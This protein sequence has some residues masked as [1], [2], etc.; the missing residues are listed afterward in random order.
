MTVA[1]ALPS[2][3]EPEKHQKLLDEVQR[4]QMEVRYLRELLRLARIAKYGPGSEQLSDEQLELLELEPGVRAEEVQAESEKA[5]LKLPLR[6]PRKEGHGRQS[7]P[8]HLPR[9][10][11]IIACTEQECVCGRCGREKTLIGYESS[12]Q[13]DFEPAR[14]LVRVTKREKRACQHCPEGGVACA[15]APKQ[16]IEKSLATDRLVIETVVSKY[17]DHLPLYRQS[18]ILLRDT[19]IELSRNTLCDWVMRVGELL[20]PI[21]EAMAQELLA[22]QY[23]QA[24]ETPVDV[25]LKDSK[26]KNHQAYLWQYSSPTGAVVFDFQLG[27]S[28]EGPKRFL[29]NYEGIL[30]TD[31]YAAYDRVGGPKIVHAGCW[32]HARRYFFQAVEA[33]PQDRAAIGLVATIDELFGLDAQAREQ[34]F[35]IQ[36]RDHLRQQKARLLLESIAKQ[37]AAAKAQCLPQSALAK[38]C[39]YTLTQWGRLSQFL[40]YPVLELSTNLAENAMRPVAVGRKNWLHFGSPQAGTRIAAIFSVLETCRRLRLPARDYLASILPGLADFPLRQVS[41]L[42]PA[43][44]AVPRQKGL[45]S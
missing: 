17:L 33:H 7:L 32:A 39:N 38:A 45:N 16:I 21:A 25:Q 35:S 26:G 43:P 29:G 27:R 30:Q 10:E 28:R 36:E 42:T 11:Q 31:G 44:W 8:A 24:D 12:E 19:G 37:I 15:P 40:D 41:Q 20:Q 14:Y 23:I 4:L 18:A 22:G 6:S 13:L 3:A 34:G 1:I 5:Q 2:P 9:V